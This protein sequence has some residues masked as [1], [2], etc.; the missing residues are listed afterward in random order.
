[1]NNKARKKKGNEENADYGADF[2]ALSPREKKI[3]LKTAKLLVK[4]QREYNT[5][6]TNANPPKGGK[7]QGIC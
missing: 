3:I 2:M 1:M 4:A 6:F 7:K 5:L